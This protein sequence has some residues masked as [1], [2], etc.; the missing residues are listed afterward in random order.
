MQSSN[1]DNETPLANSDTNSDLENFSAEF[2]KGACCP[3]ATAIME[4]YVQHQKTL[5]EIVDRFTL[6]TDKFRVNPEY[7]DDFT[8]RATIV[9][10][11]HATHANSARF[12]AQMCGV[13]GVIELRRRIDSMERANSK[14]PDDVRR[15]AI[16]RKL[17]R[18]DP[19]LIGDPSDVARI[20]M[21]IET[22]NSTEG[23][24]NTYETA[25]GSAAHTPIEMIPQHYWTALPLH[26]P[27]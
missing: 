2:I 13:F 9:I 21:V 12:A 1:P 25:I 27:H 7:E 6:I 5:S 15:L 17:V 11:L 8:A 16:A 10:E 22:I 26:T 18:K 19:H 20:N 3:L 23:F 4:R 24:L 14:F